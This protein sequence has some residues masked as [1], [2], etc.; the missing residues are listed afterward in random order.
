MSSVADQQGLVYLG[1]DV[2]KDSSSVGI[3]RGDESVPDVERIFHDGESVRR[4]ISRFADRSRLRSCYE[5]GPTGYGLHR[6]LTGLGVRNQVVAPSLVPRRAGD[7]VKTDRRDARRLARLHRAG[8][9]TAIRVPTQDEEAVRDLCRARADLLDDRHRARKRLGAFLLRHG[10]VY[11]AGSPWTMTHDRWLSGLV[12]AQR[13]A[14]VTFA[15]YR[16]ALAERDAT[17][18]AVEADLWPFAEVE[19]FGECVRRLGA[20][21]GIAR[22]GALTIATEVTDWRRFARAEAFM[23]FTGLV[24]SEYSSGDSTR[25]GHITKAGN[26]HLRT[27]LVESAWAYQHGPAVGVELRKRQHD[28]PPATIARAWAAQRR[29]CRRFRDLAGRKN[30]K[31]IVAVAIARE[32]AGFL[33]AEMTCPQHTESIPA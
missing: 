32:L 12:F 2:H 23:G 30:S 5:A 3:L 25:R 13:A 29:L 10:E 7:R 18:A 4:L 8:E 15:H 28:L 24:P 20:Y 14:A 16:A 22:L 17:L 21:R 6:E 9:L 1:L 27:Q 11:R 26:E 33:W 31:A 19:P